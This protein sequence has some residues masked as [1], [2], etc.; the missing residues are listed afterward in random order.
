[1]SCTESALAATVLR[2][3]AWRLDGF[4][5]GA[6][7]GRDVHFAFAPLA[8]LDVVPA[9]RVAVGRQAVEV[10][11][12]GVP[13]GRHCRSRETRYARAGRPIDLS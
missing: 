2:L 13:A 3:R 1:M 6:L 5:D 11:R 4:A 10:L 7:L 9:E 8:A 12:R